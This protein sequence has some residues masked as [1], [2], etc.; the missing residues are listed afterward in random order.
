VWFAQAQAQFSLA[1]ITHKRTKFHHVISQL[2]QRYAAEVEYI[3][4]SPVVGSSP[5]SI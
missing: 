2:D 1:G 5:T 3:I 4:T